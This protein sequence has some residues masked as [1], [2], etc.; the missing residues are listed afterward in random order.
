MTWANDGDQVGETLDCTDKRNCIMLTG[1]YQCTRGQCTEVRQGDK[2]LRFFFSLTEPLVPN[3][4]QMVT[5]WSGPVC[6]RCQL[7][8]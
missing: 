6:L 1:L 3:V 4:H 8:L 5:Q 7:V 2:S